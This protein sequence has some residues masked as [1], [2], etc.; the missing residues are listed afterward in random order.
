MGVII[1]KLK[2]KVNNYF[3]KGLETAL[4]FPPYISA[5]NDGVLRRTG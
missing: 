3:L 5:M 1:Q 2:R 4:P